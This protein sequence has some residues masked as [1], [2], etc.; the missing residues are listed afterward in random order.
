MRPFRVPGYPWLPAVAL[1]GSLAFLAGNLV[2]DPRGSAWTAGLLVLS[3][4]AFRL[5][6][7]RGR[8]AR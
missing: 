5:L 3:Y 1:V 7:A 8:A 2:S 4:P 6:A